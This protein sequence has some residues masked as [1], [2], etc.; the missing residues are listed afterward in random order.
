MWEKIV[1]VSV[2]ITSTEDKKRVFVTGNE[3]SQID[4]R[5]LI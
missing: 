1:S 3:M 5:N 2:N 4:N